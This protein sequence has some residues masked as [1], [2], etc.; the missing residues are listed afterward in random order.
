[1][2]W[3]KFF[4][5]ETFGKMVYKDSIEREMDLLS[6]LFSFSFSFFFTAAP[7]AYGNMEVSG[8]GVKL[9]LQLG[10]ASQP[11]QHWIPAASVTHA[12]ARAMLDP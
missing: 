8:L 2:S 9:E 12:T 3:Q 11:P 5:K 4:E 10:P 1:M 7:A 6:F